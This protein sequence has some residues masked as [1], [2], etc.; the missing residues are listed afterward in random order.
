MEATTSEISLD[1]FAF[2]SLILCCKLPT[3]PTLVNIWLQ[4][5]TKSSRKNIVKLSVDFIQFYYIVN[6]KEGFYSVSLND[7]IKLFITS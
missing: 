7:K 1:G 4:W 2:F 3:L 6:E 5:A